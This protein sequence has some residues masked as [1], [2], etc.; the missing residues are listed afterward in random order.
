MSQNQ[1]VEMEGREFGYV[2][3]VVDQLKGVLYCKH[4][5]EGVFT[6]CNAQPLNRVLLLGQ[7]W[8]NDGWVLLCPSCGMPFVYNQNVCDYTVKGHVC[9]CCTRRIRV[10]RAQEATGVIPSELGKHS[11]LHCAMCHSKIRM[12][13]QCFMFPHGIMLCQT[14]NTNRIRHL[15]R[16]ADMLPVDVALKIVADE[17]KH[18]HAIQHNHALKRR[19]VA[20]VKAAKF[21]V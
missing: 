20:D 11:Q 12:D 15:L 16:D 14:H 18:S 21:Y 13:T 5:R 9:H 7:V 8:W 17:F 1:R 2:E 3:C 10:A 19:R 4:N 6:L